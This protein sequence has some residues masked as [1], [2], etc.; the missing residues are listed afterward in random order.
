MRP[1]P[2]THQHH[3]WLAKAYFIIYWLLKKI[4]S[5]FPR[6]FV[7]CHC[8]EILRTYPEASWP[9]GGSISNNFSSPHLPWA[10]NHHLKLKKR[11][12]RF[13]PVSGTGKLQANCIHQFNKDCSA[14]DRL[15]ELKLVSIEPTGPEDFSVISVNDTAMQNQNVGNTIFCS[16]RGGG[17]CGINWSK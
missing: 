6:H 10:K 1:H 5:I 8:E 17:Y 14:R 12:K 9:G 15:R 7:H 16:K 11:F 13:L 4:P 2:L 3:G